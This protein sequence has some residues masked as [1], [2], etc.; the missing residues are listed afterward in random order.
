VTS[1]L[2]KASRRRIHFTVKGEKHQAKL[3]GRRTKVTIAGKKVKRKALKAGMTCAI[4][5]VG[6]MGQARTVA[7]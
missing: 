1:A 3:S 4:T 6:N 5:Y 7:C 2:T